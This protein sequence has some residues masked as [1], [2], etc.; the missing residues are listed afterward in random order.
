MVVINE[1]IKSEEVIKLLGEYIIENE[2]HK[3]LTQKEK[4]QNKLIHEIID[5]LLKQKV[6]LKMEEEKWVQKKI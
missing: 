4:W 6:I 2:P 3:K 1:Y 5:D